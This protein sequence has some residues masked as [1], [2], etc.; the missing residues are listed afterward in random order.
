MKNISDHDNPAELR[1]LMANAR[2][3]GREDIY[4]LAFRHL[5]ALDG[6][7]GNDALHSDFYATLCAYEELLSEK[8]SRTTRANRTRQKLA[9]HGVIKCLEDWASD[10]KE[11]QGFT[12]LVDN[13][14]VE[15]TG[16]FLVLKHPEHFSPKAISSARKRLKGV[17]DSKEIGAMLDALGIKLSD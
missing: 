17:E 16:E 1:Q 2:R 11:T 4:W 12:I 7:V 13:G 5:C 10:S 14:L 8:N 6:M 9:R 3:L 15:L